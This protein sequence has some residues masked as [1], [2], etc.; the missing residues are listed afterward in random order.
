MKNELEWYVL[1]YDFNSNKIIMYNV[2]KYWYDKIKEA[3]KKRKFNN[4]QTFKEWLKRN[5]MYYYWSKSECEIQVAGLLAKDEKEFEKIDIWYQL[6]PN[7]DNI[8]DYLIAKMN[9]RF[10]D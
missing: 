4:R 3:R 9:F 8:C 1:N 5:F 7:L 10:K 6:E 2:L